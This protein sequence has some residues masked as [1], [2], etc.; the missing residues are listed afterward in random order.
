MENALIPAAQPNP[1]QQETVDPH[2][3]EGGQPRSGDPLPEGG[4]PLLDIEYINVP[5]VQPP[6]SWS[7]KQWRIRRAILD[8]LRFWQWNGYQCLWVTLTSAPE[9]TTQRLRKD[10]QVLRKRLS[11]EFGFGA[12]EYVCVDTREGHGVLHMIWAYKDPDPVK[13]A[14]FYVPFE[15]LQAHWKDIH[16]AFHVNV[17]RIGMKDKDARRLSRYIVAQYCGDQ[18]GLVR[19]SQ[20]KIPLPLAKMRAALLRALKGSTERY[21][22]AHEW[23]PLSEE[24]FNK[25]FNGWFWGTFRSAWDELVMRLHCTAFGVQFAWLNGRIERV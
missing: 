9:Q 12:F 16:G 10:F 6:P 22:L 14:S 5:R 1:P 20:S 2:A 23:G 18:L 24:E 17:K 19:M 7:R 21:F 8:L 4:S 13:R 3:P 11:R 15:R 25:R